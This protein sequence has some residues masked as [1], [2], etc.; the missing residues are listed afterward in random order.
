MT[1]A[2]TVVEPKVIDDD[3]DDDAKET[4]EMTLTEKCLL[5][6]LSEIYDNL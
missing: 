1:S 2:I 3:G 4:E 6:L 5:F